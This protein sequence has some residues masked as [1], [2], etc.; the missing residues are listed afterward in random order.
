MQLYHLRRS[1]VILDNSKKLKFI[2][3]VRS[4]SPSGMF[5]NIN[6]YHLTVSNVP[7]A[8]VFLPN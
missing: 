1:V 4:N 6:M 8:A 2:V 5:S 7:P 3:V